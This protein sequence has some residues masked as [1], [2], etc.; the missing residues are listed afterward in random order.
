[1]NFFYSRSFILYRIESSYF[2]FQQSFF[3]YID[4]TDFLFY[5]NKRLLL[6]RTR[7]EEVLYKKQQLIE[8]SERKSSSSEIIKSN[9][10][11][12]LFI[13]RRL[14]SFPCLS[15]SHGK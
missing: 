4:V 6:K 9:Y 15:V 5:K 3:K 13:T 14:T 7:G 11:T 12:Q 10:Q 2:S 8:Q 1:M